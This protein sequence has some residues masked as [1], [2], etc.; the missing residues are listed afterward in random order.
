LGHGQ[1]LHKPS[2]FERVYAARQAVHAAELVVFSCANGLGFPRLGV[3]VGKAKHGNAV[4]RNRIKRVFR[5]AFRQS[6]QLLPQDRDYVL[7]PK[8]GVTAYTTALVCAALERAAKK[9]GARV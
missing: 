3:S 8:R 2:D 7:V 6:R 1:R 5:E 4:R 9:I